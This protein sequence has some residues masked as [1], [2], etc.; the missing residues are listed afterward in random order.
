[1][2]CGRPCD[3]GHQ[4]LAVAGRS[5][6]REVCNPAAQLKLVQS[7]S[8]AVC[9][10]KQHMPAFV[11]QQDWKANSIHPAS[12]VCSEGGT[13]VHEVKAGLACLERAVQINV[14]NDRPLTFSPK[15]FH[16][17]VQLAQH[18]RAPF[19]VDRSHLYPHT[20][21]TYSSL[22][23][24]FSASPAAMACCDTLNRASS[25]PASMRLQEAAAQHSMAQHSRA[26][27]T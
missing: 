8:A 10:H 9:V 17:T 3:C 26:P 15:P 2:A 25:Q 13:V 12:C 16:S 4:T 24:C 14:G 11:R 7:G 20:V 18:S 19:T 23:A 21:P 1:M 5:C 27:C 6:K 22:S